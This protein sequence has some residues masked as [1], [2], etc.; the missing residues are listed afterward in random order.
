MQVGFWF[1][2]Q[3]WHIVI[4]L[5]EGLGKNDVGAVK[6]SEHP[7]QTGRMGN[8]RSNASCGRTIILVQSALQ[9]ETP[10]IAR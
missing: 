10:A 6:R 7:G 9:H 4:S 2:T 1:G 3:L 8:Q 5:F